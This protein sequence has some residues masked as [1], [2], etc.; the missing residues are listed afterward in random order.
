MER[1]EAFQAELVKRVLKL[2]Q[3]SLQHCCMQLL[4][5]VIPTMNMQGLDEEAEI[6]AESDWPGRLRRS[7]LCWHYV[8]KQ[9]SICTGEGMQGTDTGQNSEDWCTAL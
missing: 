9:M 1:L 6:S 3:T 2:A 8:M 5:W 4:F 7:E